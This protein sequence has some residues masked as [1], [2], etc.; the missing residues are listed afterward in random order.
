MLRASEVVFHSVHQQVCFLSSSIHWWK[1]WAV[2]QTPDKMSEW[3][4]QLRKKQM[5]PRS[6]KIFPAELQLL[7]FR[8]VWQWGLLY[9]PVECPCYFK[10]QS[11]FTY[12]FVEYFLRAFYAVIILRTVGR[13]LISAW[14]TDAL[15]ADLHQKMVLQWGKAHSVSTEGIQ[16]QVL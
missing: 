3:D 4:V 10:I 6:K 5:L 8:C 13:S 11:L 2:V 9:H 12:S 16:V 15:P 14:S 7:L 1:P